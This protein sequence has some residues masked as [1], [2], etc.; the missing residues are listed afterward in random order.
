MIAEPTL[1]PNEDT[2]LVNIHIVKPDITGSTEK[3]RYRTWVHDLLDDND[4][5]YHIEIKSFSPSSTK[6][7]ESQ[8]IFVEEKHAETVQ[9]LLKQYIDPENFSFSEEE[10]EDDV[11]YDDEFDGVPQKKC[12]SCDEDVDFDYYKCPYCKAALN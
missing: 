2:K 5:K 9:D 6:T 11:E 7:I 1:I 12:P 4:I 10:M 3:I 8:W